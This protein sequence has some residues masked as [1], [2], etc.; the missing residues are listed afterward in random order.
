[1]CSKLGRTNKTTEDKLEALATI[2]KNS[3]GNLGDD[4]QALI[5][6]PLLDRLKKMCELLI[7]R[8]RDQ[9]FKIDT[10][11]D[12]VSLISQELNKNARARG[13]AW[14]LPLPSSQASQTCLPRIAADRLLRRPRLAGCPKCGFT[15]DYSV[16]GGPGQAAIA[17]QQSGKP[18]GFFDRM[19]GGTGE[20]P[21]PRGPD[22][23]RRPLTPPPPRR[24][25]PLS[26][27]PAFSGKDQ[28]A[29][30]HIISEP[31]RK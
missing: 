13:T 17:F 20:L 7:K 18:T 10:L 28:P 14:A 30:D 26:V 31:I 15:F 5:D 19:K 6:L 27:S 9:A 3:L 2:L 4:E 24:F 16:F 8:N 25:P 1:M 12:K 21:P 22:D 23:R 11:L 29:G